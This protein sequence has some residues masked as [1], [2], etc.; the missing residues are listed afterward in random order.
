MTTIQ[1][2]AHI[3]QDGVLRLELPTAERETDVEVT[4]LL[5]ERGTSA[6]WLEA[7]KEGRAALEAAGHAFRTTEEIDAEISGLREEREIA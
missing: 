5:Q 7:L 2:T 4:V 3:G 6:S 1:T